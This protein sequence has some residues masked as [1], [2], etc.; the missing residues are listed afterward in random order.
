MMT[1]SAAP[2]QLIALDDSSWRV[3]REPERASSTA[4]DPPSPIRDT[5]SSV[6]RHHV[7]CARVPSSPSSST[8][9]CTSWHPGRTTCWVSSRMRA[10]RS[11][12]VNGVPRAMLTGAAAITAPCRMRAKRNPM[13][14][15]TTSTSAATITASNTARSASWRGFRSGTPRTRSSSRRSSR[16]SKRPT[17]RLAPYPVPSFAMRIPRAAHL[18]SR[19]LRPDRTRTP[20]GRTFGPVDSHDARGVPS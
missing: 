19:A 13:T 17:R 14:D 15:T 8:P 9:W 5:A 2:E 4:F 18:R 20:R 6:S 12:M 16:S 11:A 10:R 3:A 7:R 1:G